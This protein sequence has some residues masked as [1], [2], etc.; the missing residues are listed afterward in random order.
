MGTFV[1]LQVILSI[2]TIAL[3]I[4]PT[5]FRRKIFFVVAA[6]ELVFVAGLRVPFA[7][8]SLVYAE[9][10]KSMVGAPFHKVISS[11]YEKGFVIYIYLLTRVSSSPQLLFLVSSII[12][13]VSVLIFIR[14]YSR[15]AWFSL[16]L[17]FS[18][19]F[20]YSFMN[21][22]RFGLAVAI[23]LFAVRFVQERRRMSFLTCI[24]AASLFHRAAILSL[25]M[26]PLSLLELRNIR[27]G[28]VLI[29]SSL[30]PSLFELVSP[31]LL[32]YSSRYT[33]YVQLLGQFQGNPANIIFAVIYSAVFLFYYS[34][35]YRKHRHQGEQNFF[36]NLMAWQLLLGAV[37]AISSVY[38]MIIIRF[39]VLFAI[40]SIVAIPE[41]LCSIPHRHDR[42]L[43]FVTVG[44][45]GLTLQVVV[46][47]WRPEWY[48]VTPYVSIIQM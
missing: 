14:R 17:Y 24:A 38:V 13:N 23:V 34:R 47:A 45:V 40:V 43:G 3:Y 46:L 31:F 9:L 39:T 12:V 48:L 29:A 35:V 20:F 28:L 22:M 5:L 25:I 33:G 16:H 37:F 44:I 41:I 42:L 26:Y 6:L 11:G 36:M 27:A 2:Q 4:Y 32:L 10:Y 18:G 19:L 1:L 30:I 15:A 8:D 7:G 21:L